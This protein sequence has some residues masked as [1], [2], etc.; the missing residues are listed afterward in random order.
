MKRF[1]LLACVLLLSACGR[2]EPVS[3]TTEPTSAK[4]ETATEAEAAQQPLPSWTSALSDTITLFFQPS[5]DCGIW[6]R[7]NRTGEEKLLL[8]VYDTGYGP[9][10]PWLIANI[11]ERY[12]AY[13]Y[14]PFDTETGG[15]MLYDVAQMRKIELPGFFLLKEVKDGKVYL[16]Q[17]VEDYLKDI[18]YFDIS[19]LDSGGPVVVKALE[20]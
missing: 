18:V 8:E 15:L 6:M 1:C 19:A 20:R 7:D 5:S 10:I 9:V 14:A 3:I 13:C 12:F 4:I 2:A 17:Y 11:N 16:Y